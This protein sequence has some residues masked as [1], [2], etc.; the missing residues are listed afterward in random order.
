M[1]I[2]LSA[3]VMI[4]SISAFAQTPSNPA[5]QSL[6]DKFNKDN[7]LSI[8]LTVPPA[9]PMVLSTGPKQPVYSHPLSSDANVFLLPQDNMP[10]IVPNTA[11][12]MP[13]ARGGI[14]KPG[15]P[16]AMPNAGY[17]PMAMAKPA[18]KGKAVI[19]QH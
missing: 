3:A 7:P 10:C 11:S 17:S 4:F 6:M 12:N 15:T 13:V 16:G 8:E 5:L 19:E 14:T 18:V 9:E 2:V 1:R